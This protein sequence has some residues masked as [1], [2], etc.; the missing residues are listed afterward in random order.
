VLECDT[1]GLS[2]FE[3]A[4]TGRVFEIVDAESF[5]GD[6]SLIGDT[7]YLC[8]ALGE[9]FNVMI[10]FPLDDFRRAPDAVEGLFE[11]AIM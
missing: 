10:R 8:R 6:S 5:D 4:A 7:A 11:E 2:P 1:D 9:S 3:L